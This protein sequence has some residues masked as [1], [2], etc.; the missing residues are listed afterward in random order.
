MTLFFHNSGPLMTYKNGLLKTANLN[1]EIETQ[2]SMSR[3][4]ML[5]LA[6]KCLVAA[7]RR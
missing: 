3:L 4:E 5:G 2:W 6:W 1:P 7:V